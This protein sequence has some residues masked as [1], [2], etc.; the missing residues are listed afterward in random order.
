MGVLPYL[1]AY[2]LR[3]K[4]VFYLKKRLL[5]FRPLVVPKPSRGLGLVVFF[6]LSYAFAWREGESPSEL[7]PVRN[8][9]A[10]LPFPSYG[11]LE[12]EDGVRAFFS[13]LRSSLI[14]PMEP[15]PGPVV[16]LRPSLE[17]DISVR[18]LCF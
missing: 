2:A 11:G 14:E 8:T 12:R 15:P 6:S 4:G 1:L 18:L 7:G 10:T 13:L 17:R 5:R 3:G 16:R 9:L